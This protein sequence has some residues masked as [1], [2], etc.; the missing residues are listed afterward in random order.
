MANENLHLTRSIERAAFGYRRTTRPTEAAQAVI[1]DG[2]AAGL[3]HY[4]LSEISR[5]MRRTPEPLGVRTE[6]LPVEATEDL[7]D[8]TKVYQMNHKYVR[9]VF[10]HHGTNR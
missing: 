5:A 1:D 8:A 2:R 4:R 10:H 3:E 6:P 7:L 9:N